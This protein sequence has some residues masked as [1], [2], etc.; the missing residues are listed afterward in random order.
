[1]GVSL[2]YPD[3]FVLLI[4]GIVFTA[5]GAGILG[6]SRWAERRYY[7]TLTSRTDMREFLES[8]P[9][10]SGYGALRMGGLISIV[11]GAVFLGIV[12]FLHFGG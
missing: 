5:V 6:W 2:P 9:E 4:M 12:A 3:S 10:R 7:D 1:V 11:V 8:T